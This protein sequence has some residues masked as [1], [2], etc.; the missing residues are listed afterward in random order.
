MDS[1]LRGG[2]GVRGCQYPLRKK[3]LSG[4][5]TKKELKIKQKRG[6]R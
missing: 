5:S 4:L 6:R 1:P 2:E 3:G